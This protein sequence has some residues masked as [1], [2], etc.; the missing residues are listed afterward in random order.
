PVQSD[1]EQ[2]A[3]QPEQIE[4]SRP[5][6]EQPEKTKISQQNS[7]KGLWAGVVCALLIVGI[8]VGWMLL[9]NR[10]QPPETQPVIAAQ[11]QIEEVTLND[12]IAEEVD[13][14]SSLLCTQQEAESAAKDT[15]VQEKISIEQEKTAHA[16]KDVQ[17]EPA[18][19]PKEEQILHNP[20]GTPTIVSLGAGER[21]TL[22]SERLYGDKNFWGYIYEVNAFQIPNP[23]VVSSKLKL[24]LPDA[25]Y[26]HIDAQD[27][28][29]VKRARQKQHE[30]LQKIRQ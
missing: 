16:T 20:D 8:F 24:Y 25:V 5:I 23:N 4:D 9:S 12:S 28:A 3:E 17:T 11:P 22:L 27:P 26:Y 21:L 7:K 2:T 15:I 10:Q 14:D 13:A 29:S 30:I 18:E 6:A 19:R 1:S